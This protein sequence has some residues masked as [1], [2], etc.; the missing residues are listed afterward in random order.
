[1]TA[2]TLV[3]IND[4][5]SRE[6]LNVDEFVV[7]KGSTFGQRVENFVR[8]KFSWKTAD[9]LNFC[10]V[11]VVNDIVSNLSLSVCF[12][13]SNSESSIF[14]RFLSPRSHDLNREHT[15]CWISRNGFSNSFFIHENKNEKRL[16]FNYEVTVRELYSTKTHIFV[17]RCSLQRVIYCWKYLRMS[18][19]WRSWRWSSRRKDCKSISWVHHE[20]RLTYAR[21]VLDDRLCFK[22]VES[23][24]VIMMFAVSKRLSKFA[25]MILSNSS[26][27]KTQVRNMITSKIGFNYEYKGWLI[28]LVW[29]LL[30]DISIRISISQ[31]PSFYSFIQ[32][33][34]F[35]V[36]EC[37]VRQ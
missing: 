35:Q 17:D 1:M 16:W 8:K 18:F 10:R 27:L 2:A 12:A 15:Q 21:T 31:K 36:T 19:W 25:K 28:Y 26:E 14:E 22:I 6:A 30:R 33:D 23:Y 24:A 34:L 13:S 9:E 7:E 29:L 3:S 37:I 11:N 20:H 4:E 32:D 5:L